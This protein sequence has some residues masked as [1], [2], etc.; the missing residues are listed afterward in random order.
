LDLDQL[1]AVVGQLQERGYLEAGDQTIT[2][3]NVSALRQL[4]ELLA[5][6]EEVRHGLRCR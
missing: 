6:K 5:L 1:K 3:V 2:I 4:H